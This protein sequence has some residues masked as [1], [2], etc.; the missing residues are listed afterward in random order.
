MSKPR[1]KHE[2]EARGRKIERTI[3]TDTSKRLNSFHKNEFLFYSEALSENENV[4]LARIEIKQNFVES[5]VH[6]SLQTFFCNSFTYQ[7]FSFSLFLSSA[8]SME[9]FDFMDFMDRERRHLRRRERERERVQEKRERERER[10]EY[11]KGAVVYCCKSTE[12]KVTTRIPS[13]PSH[14]RSL[15]AKPERNTRSS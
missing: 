14:F 6:R 8:S 7:S 2:E 13:L 4:T 9:L 3:E 1:P 10:E 11:S 15:Q 5:P 12:S